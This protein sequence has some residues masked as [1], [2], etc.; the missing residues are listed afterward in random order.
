MGIFSFPLFLK[1]ALLRH[2]VCSLCGTL[3]PTHCSFPQG[4]IWPCPALKNNEIGRKAQGHWHVDNQD[5]HH[6]LC[7]LLHLRV[8]NMDWNLPSP[9][10]LY[11][12][13]NSS[14]LLLISLS[15]LSQHCEKQNARLVLWLCNK[16]RILEFY[17][18]AILFRNH[19][20]NL[21][22]VIHGAEIILFHMVSS[23][24]SKQLQPALQLHVSKY[25]SGYSV[26]IIITR[27]TWS[28]ESFP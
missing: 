5:W 27:K 11:L 8:F 24:G 4:R 20:I 6:C 9:A 17:T 16:I 15:I 7:H 12:S 21:C 28:I 2:T 25:D 23:T 10:C 18:K 3:Q 22:S 19:N 1:L 13:M 26:R 14:A